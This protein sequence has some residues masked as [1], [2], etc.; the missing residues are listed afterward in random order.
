MQVSLLLYMIYI[1]NKLKFT[2]VHILINNYK[3][4]KYNMNIFNN[5]NTKFYFYGN[6]FK[7]ILITH[8]LKY[9]VNPIIEFICI[10]L[11]DTVINFIFDRCKLNNIVLID[12][13]DCNLYDD[14]LDDITN[15]IE[16]IP[17]N[18]NELYIKQVI[19]Y[20]SLVKSINIT[21]RFILLM[22]IKKEF[23]LRDFSRYFHNKYDHLHI[24]YINANGIPFA[25]MIDINTGID[26]ITKK[27]LL[28]GN[29]FADE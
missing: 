23:N 5:M 4:I 21:K 25:K 2:I 14:D 28:F 3:F 13:Y 15:E 16:N 9:I 1:D 10:Y 26:L 6:I 29:I 19:I 8:V 22:A 20:N 18:D 17:N 24:S 11:N 27:K 12:N 7:Y